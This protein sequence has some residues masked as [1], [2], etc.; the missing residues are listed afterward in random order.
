MN[1]SNF[2]F[3][4]QYYQQKCVHTFAYICSNGTIDTLILYGQTD[5]HSRLSRIIIY[6][7]KHKLHKLE[8]PDARYGTW[9]SAY[10]CAWWALELQTGFLCMPNSNQIEMH[11][12]IWR[13]PRKSPRYGIVIAHSIR[14]YS[15]FRVTLAEEINTHIVNG[16][17]ITIKHRLHLH[18]RVP[19][20][21][22]HK[23][24]S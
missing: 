23:V 22:V 6:A 5:N 1:T 13:I 4:H 8:A 24:H 2:F 16:S 14:N 10:I 11:I 7:H 12:H 17:A 20:R 9:I 19:E 15:S 3:V 21:R 18:H